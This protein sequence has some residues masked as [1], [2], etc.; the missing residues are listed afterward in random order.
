MT[1]IPTG[2]IATNQDQKDQDANKQR[3]YETIK[4]RLFQIEFDKYM[5]E[6]RVKRK[7]QMGSMDRSD[8]IRTYNFPQDRIS[9][10]L[11]LLTFQII[12]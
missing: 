8:K 1:H 6:L 12:E 3:A 2:T 5:T 7:G 11:N 10:I 9:G 4:E